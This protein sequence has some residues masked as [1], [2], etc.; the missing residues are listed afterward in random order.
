MISSNYVSIPHYAQQSGYY[1]WT[2]DSVGHSFTVGIDSDGIPINTDGNFSPDNGVPRTPFNTT[3]TFHM[4]RL[5]IDDG[6][7]VIDGTQFA[8]TPLGGT[9]GNDLTD[10]FYWNSV[11]FRDG[12]GD[13]ASETE[14]RSFQFSNA[15]PK[16]SSFLLFG[17][18][19]TGLLII[20]RRL[21]HRRS[22]KLPGSSRSG[23]GVRGTVSR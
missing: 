6:L 7:G 17:F 14:L 15:V 18:G 16:P 8:P 19:V 12:S 20:G 13:G 4:Y 2:V 23:I 21:G 10:P 9:T 1:L 5:V 3:D 22:A 11:N